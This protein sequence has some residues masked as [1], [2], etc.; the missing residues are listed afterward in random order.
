MRI[1]LMRSISMRAMSLRRKVAWLTLIAILLTLL[2]GVGAVQAQKSANYNLTLNSLAGGN[3]GGGTMSSASYTLVVSNG[4]LVQVSTTSP[5][6]ELCSGF[7]C[8]SN[9]SFFQMRMPAL[10]KSATD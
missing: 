5:G 8:Q 6:Y 4:T 2:V 10:T 3:R 9:Q 7:V 1:Y